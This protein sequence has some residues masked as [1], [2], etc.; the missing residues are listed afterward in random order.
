MKFSWLN[1]RIR[2][3]EL[4]TKLFDF[5]KYYK[6][7]MIRLSKKYDLNYLNLKKYHTNCLNPKKYHTNFPNPKKYHTNCLNLKK[8]HT[9]YLLRKYRISDFLTNTIVKFLNQSLTIFVTREI[10]FIFKLII[11]YLSLKNEIKNY[12]KQLF[13]GF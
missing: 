13:F 12:F 10:N 4:S 2:L 11:F 7:L 8:Y 1:I 3:Q 6:I 5:R 9:N